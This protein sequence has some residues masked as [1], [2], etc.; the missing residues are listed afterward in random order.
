M[1]GVTLQGPSGRDAVDLVVAQVAGIDAWRREQRSLDLQEVVARSREM[2]LDAARRRDAR[3]RESDA[4]LRRAQEH[5][6]ASVY[7]LTVCSPRRAVVAHRS[8]WWRRGLGRE[9]ELAGIAVVASGSDGADALGVAVVEQPDLLVLEDLLPTLSGTDV[10]RRA[11]TLFP[12]TLVALHASDR[13]AE[14][15]ARGAGAHLVFPRQ[16][17]PALVAQQVLRVLPALG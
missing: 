15:G 11:R 7:V 2:R 8:D 9:L 6:E 10:A 3:R 4:V 13:E 1:G 14:A 17:A 5:L 16:T 12:D